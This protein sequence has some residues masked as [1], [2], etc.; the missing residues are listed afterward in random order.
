MFPKVG[1]TPI[2]PCAKAWS[3]RNSIDF[4]ISNIKHDLPSGESTGLT[5]HIATTELFQE[6][7]VEAIEQIAF[8]KQSGEY[9]SIFNLLFPEE[10]GDNGNEPPKN[11]KGPKAP[12]VAAQS[13][14]EKFPRGGLLLK[15]A[16]GEDTAI[17]FDANK[18]LGNVLTDAATEKKAKATEKEAKAAEAKAAAA[19][20]AKAKQLADAKA[21][22][23]GANNKR[24]QGKDGGL[25]S[26]SKDSKQKTPKLAAQTDSTTT[27]IQP[28]VSALTAVV[29]NL[30]ARSSTMY[31]LYEH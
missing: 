17:K 14:R 30:A 20:A 23:K 15:V 28:L 19:K 29:S 16:A 13:H 10:D 3:I 1:V 8:A 21:P 11:E 24:K 31:L 27:T 2:K 22:A 7:A 6:K 5:I 9:A 25:P 26:S 18:I 12:P 4:C